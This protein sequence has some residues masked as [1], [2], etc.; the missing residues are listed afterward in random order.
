LV[1]GLLLIA[2]IGLWLGGWQPL[3][4]RSDGT[5]SSVPS[6]P[7]LVGVRVAFNYTNGS[8]GSFGAASS[9]LCDGCPI[10]LTAGASL[11]F[12]LVFHNAAGSATRSVGAI[13]V[14]QPFQLLSENPAVPFSVPAGGVTTLQ[15]ALKAPAGPG[16]FILYIN[17]TID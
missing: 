10:V 9:A 12:P 7:H 6:R 5:S 3:G 13:G 1:L 15:L 17:A 16:D 11:G 4:T 8:A 14:G 2:V